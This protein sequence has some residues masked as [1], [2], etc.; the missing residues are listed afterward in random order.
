M[1]QTGG[2]LGRDEADQQRVVGISGRLQDMFQ[3][4]YA[5][6]GQ[7]ITEGGQEAWK[8]VQR[9]AASGCGDVSRC[10]GGTTVP[11]A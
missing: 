10:A 3:D 5:V 8:P 9:G 4:D 7:A 6:C 2:G 1:S 11:A